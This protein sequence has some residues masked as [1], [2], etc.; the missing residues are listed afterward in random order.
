VHDESMQ[1]EAI[2][3]EQ[4][5]YEATQ[6]LLQS[7]KKVDAIVCASDL[8][9]MG[10]MRALRDNDIRIP[11]Q[12]AVTGYDNI[13]SSSFTNPALTTMQQNTKLAGEILVKNL[14][15]L[16]NGAQLSQVLLPVELVVRQSCGAQ[17]STRQLAN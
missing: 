10:A 13:P 6:S 2:T 12:V 8:I 1:I 14:L 5:G 15:Q 9:A 17:K 4:S 16:I 3:T 11:E 7:G